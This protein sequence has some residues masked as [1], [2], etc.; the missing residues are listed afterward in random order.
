MQHGDL[1]HVSP[2]SAR[3]S[4]T[5]ASGNPH[6]AGLAIVTERGEVAS[7][8]REAQESYPG[9]HGASRIVHRDPHVLKVRPFA[10]AVVLPHEHSVQ[11]GPSADDVSVPG[12]LH[13]G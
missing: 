4:E 13:G 12:E 9:S 11:F 7:A 2:Q 6:V 5:V 10:L 3:Y 1:L 8:R